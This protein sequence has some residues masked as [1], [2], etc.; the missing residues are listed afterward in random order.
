[1]GLKGLWSKLKGGLTKTRSVFAGIKG[2][3]RIGRR[4]DQD[5]LDELE[6]H[7]IQADIC[8]EVTQRIIDGLR[9]AHR[10]KEV[11]ADLT[12]YV[13]NILREE[14]TEKEN[15]LRF[16]PDGPTVIIVVGVN[17]VGKTT[18]IAKL[19]R[20]LDQQGKSVV[21]AA[22]DTFRAAA[23]DQLETWQKRVGVE[24]VKNAPG[25]DP[26][27]VAHDAC[28]RAVA[29]KRDVVIVDTAGRLHTRDDLMT[30]LA[31]I[32]RVVGRVVPGA[33]HEVLLVLD[34]T[35]GQNAIVQAE[36]FQKFVHL[37]GIFL[38]KLDGTAKGG[39][40]VAIKQR[41]DIPVKFIGV[42]EQP[43]D[44]EPFAADEFVEALFAD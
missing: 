30:E 24:I 15:A 26:A 33:P 2:L 6:A 16:N 12:D 39:I 11:T 14:L 20:M 8:W 19:A 18:S 31:K 5:F 3:L 1:M 4:I 37:S 32:H 22:S 23:I 10:G 40:I 43:D 38:A 41:I 35:T 21:L 17:G 25:A 27:S 28:E 9:D 44:I 42:G 7:L 36:R 13:K 29:R 34:A